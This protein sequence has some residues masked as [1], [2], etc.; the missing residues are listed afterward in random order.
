MG[1]AAMKARDRQGDVMQSEAFVQGFRNHERRRIPCIYSRAAFAE[2]V[3]DGFT[4]DELGQIL[5]GRRVVDAF[6]VWADENIS[7]Y[8]RRAVSEIMMAYVAQDTAMQG[9]A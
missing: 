8:A 2:A 9:V 5:A 6:P 1:V 4:P 7:S 3:E